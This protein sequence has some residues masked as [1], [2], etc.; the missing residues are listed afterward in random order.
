MKTSS[1]LDILKMFG[2]NLHK[3]RKGKN[4]TLE[5]LSAHTGA[6][7]SDIAK[8]KGSE[9]NFALKHCTMLVI[10]LNITIPAL[11]DFENCWPKITLSQL[12]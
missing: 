1:D 6:D 11:V 7:A 10:G 9:I 8:I 2:Q 4:F 12:L 3:I 5:K